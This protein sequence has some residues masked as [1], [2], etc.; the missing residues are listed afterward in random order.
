MAI[1]WLVVTRL[2][3]LPLISYAGSAIGAPAGQSVVSN[4]GL[5]STPSSRLMSALTI[6]SGV[7]KVGVLMRAE[8]SGSGIRG[9]DSCS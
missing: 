5:F 6:L 4:L 7:A 3:M 9:G 1:L 8:E 2:L